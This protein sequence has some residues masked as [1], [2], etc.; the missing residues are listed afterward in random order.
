M[1]HQT[2][3]ENTLPLFKEWLK[4]ATEKGMIKVASFFFVAHVANAAERS[5]LLGMLEAAHDNSEEMRLSRVRRRETSSF[6]RN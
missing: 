2:I 6:L 4:S 5:V 1:I 3:K